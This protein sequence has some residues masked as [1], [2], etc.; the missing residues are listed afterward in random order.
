MTHDS[1]WIRN[2][3][4]SIQIADERQT[5]RIFMSA[6]TSNL[7]YKFQFADRFLQSIA[8]AQPHIRRKSGHFVETFGNVC[9]PRVYA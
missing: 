8:T 9:R 6:N 2:R 4:Y 5:W 3:N 7:V 1:I